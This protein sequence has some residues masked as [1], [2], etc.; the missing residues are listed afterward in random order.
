MSGSSDFQIETEVLKK[1]SDK[2]RVGDE[3]NI[4]INIS[5][6]TVKKIKGSIVAIDTSKEI[7]KDDDIYYK[8]IIAT[9]ENDVQLKP[10]MKVDIVINAII[11]RNVLI[12]PESAISKKD[13]VFSVVLMENDSNRSV[14]IETGLRSNGMVEVL[15]G[16]YE[17]DRV[18]VR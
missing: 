9:S 2:L 10:D 3:V 1:D 6:A 11:K 16:L 13:D 18:I 7:S 5:D 12:I 17:G 14:D 15:S 8:V 4:D